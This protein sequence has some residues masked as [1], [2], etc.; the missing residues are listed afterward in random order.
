MATHTH[1][2]PGCGK[3]GIARSR[4]ACVPCWG[5]LPQDLRD[6]VWRGWKV[7]AVYPMQHRAAV[8]AAMD[9]YRRDRASQAREK[10]G[11]NPARE[12]SGNQVDAD[13]PRRDGQQEA[14]QPKQ[15]KKRDHSLHNPHRTPDVR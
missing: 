7:R 3:T 6:A 11:Q 13:N 12:S 8:V 9:W 2:C 10:H 15:Q 5:R 4:L 14:H 1:I